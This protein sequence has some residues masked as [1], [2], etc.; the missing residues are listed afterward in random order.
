MLDF[1][2]E[3]ET[4]QGNRMANKKVVSVPGLKAIGPYSQAVNAA[5]LLFVAGQPGVDLR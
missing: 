1:G 2:V 4:V 3:K 5:G